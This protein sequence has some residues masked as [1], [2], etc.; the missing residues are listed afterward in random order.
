[1]VTMLHNVRSWFV[2]TIPAHLPQ[3]VKVDLAI[4][5]IA[6]LVMVTVIAVDHVGQGNFSALAGLLGG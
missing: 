5:M 2:G 6:L 1:V 4:A 3:L